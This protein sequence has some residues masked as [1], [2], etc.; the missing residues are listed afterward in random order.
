[1]AVV[2]GL[3]KV[4]YPRENLPPVSIFP[5][6]TIGHYVRYRVVSEDRNRYSHWSPVYATKLPP[7]PLLGQVYVSNT[8]ATVNAVWGDELN[9]PRYDVF[10]RWGNRVKKLSSTGTTRTI[11]TNIDHGFKVGDRIAINST[12]ANYNNDTINPYWTI[13]E[14]T[15]NTIT[16]I[17]STPQTESNTNTA[18][19]V[20][21]YNC[22]YHG[23]PSVHSYSFMRTGNVIIDGQS[24]D[25]SKFE[26]VHVDVQVESIDKVYNT[27]LLIYDTND[28][29][30]YIFT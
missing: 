26:L 17:G 25:L 12:T 6:G 3:Q 5:D 14:T 4:R 11:K 22:Y 10:I 15:H 18:G 24:H 7:F 19:Y 23:T 30:G 28:N 13:T 20:A 29:Y 8:P 9:R 1:M 16:F 2:G 27:N 21:F